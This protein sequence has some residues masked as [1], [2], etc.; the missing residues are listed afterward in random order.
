MKQTEIWAHRGAS[1]YAPENT[2]EAFQLAVKMEADGVELDVQLTKDDKLVVLH[3]ETIDRVSNGHGYVK[4]FTLD[5]LKKLRFNKLHPEYTEATIP[6]LREVFQLLEPTGLKIN[7]ELKTSY[8]FYEGIEEKVLDLVEQYGMEDRIWYSSFNHYSVK[9]IKEL[10]PKAKIGLLYGDGIYEPAAYAKT[11][12]AEALHPSISNLQY[13]KYM[14]KCREAGIKVH[15]WT[16]NSCAEIANCITKKLDAVITNYPDRVRLL[17]KQI[18]QGEHAHYAFENPS[19]MDFNKKFYLFGAGYQGEQFLK[20]YGKKYCP[21]KVIDNASTK[22][23]TTLENVEIASP[24]CLQADDC[25]VISGS[26][27]VEIV[28]QLQQLGIKDFYIYDEGLNW[29]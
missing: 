4:D 8:F 19:E 14:E 5:E 6:T 3:D 28:E 26:Y 20:K 15:A 22:W 13:P 24:D 10:R 1:A 21:I 11:V 25:V 16:A 2:L 18:G 17:M 12:G 9:K 23:G 27:F 29:G 7:I